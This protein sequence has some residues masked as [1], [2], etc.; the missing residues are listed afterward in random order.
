M[1]L[2][3]FGATGSIGLQ[4]V[5]QAL[6]AGH[7]VTAFVRTPAKLTIKHNNL[8]V[9]Q[10]DVL[11]LAAVV[12]AVAGQEAV[13]CA[14]G[15]GLKGKLRA[16]GTRNIIQAMAQAGVERLICQTTL[17]VGDS[18]ANLNFYWKYIMFKGLLGQ[19]YADHVQQEAFVKQSALKWTIVRP[20]AFTAGPRT[21]QYRHGFAAT[22]KTTKLSISRA[23]VADYMLKQLTDDTYLYKT[24]GLSY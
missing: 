18:W 11:N 8:Q 1:K 2:T 7:R 6:E 16:A 14:L 19:A 15:A 3:I 10:G 23:D 5:E 17:G 9:V 4:L 24:P 20:G 21:G 13:L 22:D 12:Q